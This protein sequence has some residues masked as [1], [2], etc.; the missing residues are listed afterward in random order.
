MCT[1]AMRRRN[2]HADTRWRPHPGGHDPCAAGGT[3]LAAAGAQRGVGAQGSFRAAGGRSLSDDQI[4][5]AGPGDDA[6]K[7]TD[8][9]IP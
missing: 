9:V 5:Q 6:H 8:G 1:L 7:R 2:L 4:Y 3:E